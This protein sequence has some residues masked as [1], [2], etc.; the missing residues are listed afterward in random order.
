MKAKYIF[1]ILSPYPNSEANFGENDVRK[2]DRVIS[3]KKK[4]DSVQVESWL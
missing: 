1:L 4:I 2:D 3:E